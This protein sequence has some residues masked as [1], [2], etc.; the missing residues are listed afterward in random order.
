VVPTQRPAAVALRRPEEGGGGSG[1]G[2][3]GG[4]ATSAPE[5][6]DGGFP[7]QAGAVE[8][9]NPATRGAASVG[10]ARRTA[11]LGVPQAF[12]PLFEPAYADRPGAVAQ[13]L[14]IEFAGATVISPRAISIISPDIIVGALGEFGGDQSYACTASTSSARRGTAQSTPGALGRRS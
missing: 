9:R 3:G 2:G 14:R 13:L 7:A 8:R 10:C 11:R 12:R 5:E 4:G 1:S 6:G